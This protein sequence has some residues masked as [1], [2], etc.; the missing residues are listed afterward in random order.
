MNEV[1]T[2]FAKFVFGFRRHE[3]QPNTGLLG[4]PF[5]DINSGDVP[6]FQQTFNT[7][8][9]STESPPI[10]SEG[11]VDVADLC[12][13]LHKQA[14]TTCGAPVIRFDDFK[15]SEFNS[16]DEIEC[17]MI[18]ECSQRMEQGLKNCKLLMP[19]GGLGNT[20]YSGLN[21]QEQI[22]LTY[23]LASHLKETAHKL[24]LIIGFDQPFGE[25]QIANDCKAPL[26]L[27]DNLIRME[28]PLAAFCLEINL[29]YY[30][31]GTWIRDLFAFNDLLDSW[32]QFD[33]PLIVQLRIPGGVQSREDDDGE[34]Y[35]AAGFDSQA[36][37]LEKIAMLALAKQNVAGVFY[38]QVFDQPQDRYF[39]AGLISVQRNGKPALDIAR[40]VKQAMA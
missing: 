14:V 26:Q 37:W 25:I 29:G 12:Q 36:S 4:A 10:D 40:R 32:G 33:Y 30:P 23:E 8:I 16:I 21:D 3:K 27:A 7:A 17:W 18:N 2:Q 34:Q 19:V 11:P 22:H 15:S 39:G 20:V 1:G 6:G 5:F 31:D 35:V 13:Q 38:A 28:T 24:P 9:I